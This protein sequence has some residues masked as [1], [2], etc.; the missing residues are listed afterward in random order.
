MGEKE[1]VEGVD[2]QRVRIRDDRAAG[3]D[4]RIPGVDDHRL[5]VRKFQNGAVTLPHIHKMDAQLARAAFGDVGRGEEHR[6]MLQPHETAV[7]DD[8]RRDGESEQRR[9]DDALAR[10]GR[11]SFSVSFR[12]YSSPPPPRTARP[13]GRAVLRCGFR[14]RNAPSDSKYEARRPGRRARNAIAAQKSGPR[15]GKPY[16]P[17][18]S[19]YA[20]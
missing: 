5:A 16:L 17:A 6:Q 8:A 3:R 9:E 7:D 15:E 14:R 20:P 1:D 11:L 18:A 13:N 10:R 12:L 19:A 4:A 2:A